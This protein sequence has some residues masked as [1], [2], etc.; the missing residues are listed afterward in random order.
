MTNKILELAHIH[1]GYEGNLILEDV[2]FSVFDR[3]FIGIIG[4][5]GG[6]KTTLLKVI[7][8]LIRPFSGTV[9][10]YFNSDHKD[11]RRHIGYLPQQNDID[12]DF[13]IKVR[14][15][16]LSGLLSG[17]TLFRQFTRDDKSRAGAILEKTG[18]AHLADTPVGELSGG[19]LQRVLLGRAVI[20]SP[21]LLILDEPGTFVDNRFE[22]ELYESLRELNHDMAILLVSH[23]I[24][25]ISSY[26]KTIAC[27]NRHLHY[28]PS[29]EIT[30]EQL[31]VY[32][33][34]IDIITHG[35]VPHR[36]LQDHQ[37]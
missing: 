37:K 15:V 36:V 35:T 20:A 12:R 32:N 5:N 11:Y 14:E 1:A 27:V 24:G 29:N 18:L 19:Q 10:Y 8:G 3:D 34:P 33:C 2:S 23:D 26:I 30:N 9:N 6:G 7:L 31:K 4:P 21:S 28:H 25:T 17:K 22:Y 16:V 13:P